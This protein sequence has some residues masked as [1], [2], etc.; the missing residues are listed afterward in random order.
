MLGYLRSKLEEETV[1]FVVDLVSEE[2]DVIKL[3]KIFQMEP[4][5]RLN[6]IINTKV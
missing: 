1:D 6:T 3:T 5:R 2:G 4:K